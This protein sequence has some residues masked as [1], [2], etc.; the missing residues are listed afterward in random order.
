MPEHEHGWT[1]V[2]HADGCHWYTSTYACVCG[3]TLRDYAERDTREDPYSAIWFD[4][5]EGPT[6]CE[7]CKALIA[8]ATP[9]PF[10]SE[11]LE[12]TT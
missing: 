11:I 6:Q 5:V 2:A 1:L 10:S 3:A 7:R 9:A 4:D 8:G 12:R